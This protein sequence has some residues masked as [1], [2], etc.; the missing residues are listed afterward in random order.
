[1]L[2]AAGLLGFW[3][4]D[5]RWNASAVWNRSVIS[6]D[7]LAPM[8]A[9]CLY[10][11]AYALT[12]LFVQ[13]TFF[14]HRTPLLASILTFIIPALWTIVPNLVL[15]F[16]NRLSWQ[17]IEQRQLGNA[18][19]VI[20]VNDGGVVLAHVWFAGVWVLLAVLANLPWFIRQ[21]RTFHPLER[22]AKPATP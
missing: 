5:T 12:G 17:V 21:V 11:H 9:L 22:S 3:E 1:L 10:G 16:V 8:L 2:T 13:R 19:N 15:F 18:F 14:P 4:F 20:L 7:T 6:T